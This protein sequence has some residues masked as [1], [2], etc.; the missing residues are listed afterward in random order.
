MDLAIKTLKHS[1][2]DPIV[3]VRNDWIWSIDDAFRFIQRERLLWISKAKLQMDNTV[4]FNCYF[5]DLWNE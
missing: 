3:L 1:N 4:F 2:R 5:Y